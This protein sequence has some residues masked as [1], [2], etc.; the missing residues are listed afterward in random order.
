V[1][2]TEIDWTTTI[3]VTDHA[4]RRAGQRLGR[5]WWPDEVA[6][7]VRSALLFDRVASVRPNWTR[8]DVNGGR[9][10]GTRR[11]VFWDE[12]ISRCW[13]LLLAP[14]ELVVAT[15]FPS[16]EESGRIARARLLR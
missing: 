5:R 8:G 10:D 7:E 9:D 1:T 2:A 16:D 11:Y 15:V 14:G 3:R 13:A 6:A 4:I 12:S